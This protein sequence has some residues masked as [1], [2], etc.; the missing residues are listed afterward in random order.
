[1]ISVHKVGLITSG[2]KEENPGPSL[3]N[4]ACVELHPF[5]LKVAWSEKPLIRIC[6]IGGLGSKEG[7]TR[8]GR[9]ERL[10]LGVLLTSCQQIKHIEMCLLVSVTHHLYVS[11]G[12]PVDVARLFSH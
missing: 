3:S 5:P 1:M 6:F 11:A 9:G 10:S 4:Q 2:Q 12:R 7:S 8:S